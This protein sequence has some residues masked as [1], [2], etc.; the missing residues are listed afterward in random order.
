MFGDNYIYFIS[1]TS[2][3]FLSHNYFHHP[4]SALIF[5]KLKSDATS[6][7]LL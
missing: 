6:K 3:G 2:I 7:K 4:Y 1:N 5:N